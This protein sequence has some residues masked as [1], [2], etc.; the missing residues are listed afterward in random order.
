MTKVTLCSCTAKIISMTTSI[1]SP[2][3]VPK[4]LSMN[5]DRETDSIY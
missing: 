2:H 1:S 5:D 3:I 4:Q